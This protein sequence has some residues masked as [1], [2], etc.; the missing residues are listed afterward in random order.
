MC[1]DIWTV[2]TLP[3]LLATRS[4]TPKVVVLLQ[5]HRLYIPP[6]VY[7]IY[8]KMHS[9]IQF[10]HSCDDTF[11]TSRRLHLRSLKTI[12]RKSQATFIP[13]L[14]EKANV[15]HVMFDVSTWTFKG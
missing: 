5:N 6:E 10:L 3:A 1:T 14:L 8:G 13:M 7:L 9:E 4:S 15:Y 12:L 11:F 2:V